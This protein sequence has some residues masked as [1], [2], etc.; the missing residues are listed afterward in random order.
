V[1]VPEFFVR[2][3]CRLRP[4]PGVAEIRLHLAENVLGLWQQTEDELG[5]G[6][7]PPFWAFAWP[8]GQ[9]LARYVLDHSALVAGRSVL[10]LGSGSG[11]VAI[12]A[13]MAGATTVLASEVDPLAVAAIGLNA[14]ANGARAPAIVGDV[15]DGDAG[16]AG[17]AAGAEVILAGDVWY[18]RSLAE[19]VL[20]FLDRAMARG[21][22]VLT[23][24]IGR[25]FLPR[26]RFRVLDARDIPV[27]AE[28]ED[29]G[30]KRTMVWAPIQKAPCL[31]HE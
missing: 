7:P 3:A 28:L 26:D 11:L 13:A 9:A 17:D 12:A 8:G 25:T 18:S 2:S 20:G 5:P 16:D 6:Q 15:L 29:S 27:M 30:V 1:P 10:D 22:S 14:R 23:G 31:A 4:V 19:R 21:A 24:D